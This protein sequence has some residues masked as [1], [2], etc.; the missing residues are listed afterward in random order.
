MM[1]FIL[2]KDRF[3]ALSD[4]ADELVQG[5]YHQKEDVQQTYVTPIFLISFS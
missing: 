5:N 2:Q 1:L 3:S 4:L